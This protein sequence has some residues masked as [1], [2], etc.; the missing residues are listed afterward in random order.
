MSDKNLFYTPTK[1]VP[2]KKSHDFGNEQIHYKVVIIHC[3]SIYFMVD[4]FGYIPALFFLLF[5]QQETSV[6]VNTFFSQREIYCGIHFGM[7]KTRT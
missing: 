2:L 6:Y 5:F 1:N 4:F 3:C 7:N